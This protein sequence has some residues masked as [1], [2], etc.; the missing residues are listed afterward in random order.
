L[1]YERKKEKDFS[2]HECRLYLMIAQIYLYAQIYDEG[3]VWMKK[4]K[5]GSKEFSVCHKTSEFFLDLYNVLSEFDRGDGNQS[6]L[7]RSLEIIQ[8]FREGNKRAKIDAYVAE[9]KKFENQGDFYKTQRLI[10]M[11][12]KAYFKS[13]TYFKK[14]L[15]LNPKNHLTLFVI[16][17]YLALIN[18]ALHVNKE[19]RKWHKKASR[20]HK[21]SEE[22]SY[23]SAMLE[24]NKGRILYNNEDFTQAK[25]HYKKALEI[26][27][28]NLPEG[29]SLTL[30]YEHE[31]FSL[32]GLSVDTTK[33]NSFEELNYN[34]YKSFL[35]H[36]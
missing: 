11:S 20:L 34:V 35:R 24:R 15:D 5:E 1:K 8:N 2:V 9:G 22:Y 19:G 31:H 23:F 12:R 28:E 36:S 3:E 32:F 30:K 26:F 29:N 7:K 4:A 14:A 21:R 25:D 18:L 10:S 13:Q 17:I 27:K 6:Y 16:Y 33:V